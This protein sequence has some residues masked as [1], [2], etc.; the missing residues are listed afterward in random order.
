MI[1]SITMYLKIEFIFIVR[2]CDPTS[3]LHRL[4][5]LA[6]ALL[7]RSFCHLASN[8]DPGGYEDESLFPK[9]WRF[10]WKLGVSN[11]I[12]HSKISSCFWMFWVLQPSVLGSLRFGHPHMLSDIEWCFHGHHWTWTFEV[13][14]INGRWTPPNKARSGRVLDQP[15]KGFTVSICTV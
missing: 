8:H 15:K 4:G 3:V 7:C 11:K 1:Y 5:D 13:A 2:S 6:D 14:Q 10:D 9:V 12:L